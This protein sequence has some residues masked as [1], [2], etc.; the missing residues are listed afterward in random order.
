[1]P[2]ANRPGAASASA[3]ALIA[4][5]PGPPGEGGGDRGAQPQPGLPGG[6]QRQR[7]E[8]VGAVD[9]GRPQVGETG[10][11]EGRVE[12]ACSASG[13]PVSGTVMPHRFVIRSMVPARPR[14]NKG[15]L[16]R[17]PSPGPAGML[18]TPGGRGRRQ[19]RAIM[20]GGDRAAPLRRTGPAQGAT[21]LELFFDLVY[22]FALTHGTRRPTPL[23]TPPAHPTAAVPGDQ[24]VYVKFDHQHDTNFLITGD[25]GSGGAVGGVM[26]VCRLWGAESRVVTAFDGGS[27]PGWRGTRG[28]RSVPR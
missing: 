14:R 5:R 21:F 25:S 23:T 15:G 24:E 27:H 18:L 8:R 12:A 3:A 11:F 9:L 2:S 10:P 26:G 19:L 28:A 13:T 17:C 6:G 1:M 7:G 22:V 4:S 16:S 20:T